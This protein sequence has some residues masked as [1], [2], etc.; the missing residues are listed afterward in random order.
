MKINFPIGAW[1]YKR[2]EDFTPDEVDT[3]AELGLTAPISPVIDYGEDIE[4]AIPFLDRAA[5]KGIQLIMNMHGVTYSDIIDYGEEEVARRF[6]EVYG[7]LKGHPGL[8]G[9]NAG[10]EPSSKENLDATVKILKIMKETAP[11]L[12]PF[13]NFQGI[14]EE[15]PDDAFGDMT[16]EEWLKKL[17]KETGIK[18]IC[19]DEYEQCINDH[20]ITL[21]LEIVRRQV[22]AIRAAG[23]TP[24]I[25]LLS[26]G[27]H[28]YHTPS[29][30]EFSLQ[31]AA[32]AALGCKGFFWFKLYDK[33][34]SADMYGSPYDEFGNRTEQ[35]YRLLR[36]NRRFLL[37]YSEI[38]SGLNLRKTYVVTGP[39]GGYPAMTEETDEPVTIDNIDSTL[40]SFFTDDEGKEYI[41]PVNL[42]LQYNYTRLR[43]RSDTSKYRVYVVRQNGKE[44]VSNINDVDGDD[45]YLHPGQMSMFRIEKI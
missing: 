33:D 11:E 38:F 1:I 40:V 35:Y 7:R 44:R 31:I 29:E 18:Y 34:I 42:A 39:R 43:F 10:D 6:R 12:E 26:T 22:A 4:K 8:F 24:W 3:W 15:Y 37:H 23:A 2:F 17:V 41:V 30:Y 36:C 27:H 14:A 25:T 28:V 16:Y 19:F 13:I 9:F 20:G 32:S 21:Y 45:F 5:E